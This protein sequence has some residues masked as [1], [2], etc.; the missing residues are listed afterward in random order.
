MAEFLTC[1]HSELSKRICVN[2]FTPKQV[3]AD[4]GDDGDNILYSLE[5]VDDNVFSINPNTG[6]ISLLQPLDREE[7]DEWNF[8]VKAT[9]EGGMEGF[10]EVLV[11]VNNENDN[12]PIMDPEYVGSVR[13]DAVV[14]KWVL[15]HIC[16]VYLKLHSYFCSATHCNADAVEHEQSL[17]RQSTHGQD[18]TMT[19][20]S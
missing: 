12:P 14:G 9:D 4:D 17:S 16:H 18:C 8:L 13:E 3:S 10:A 20:D 5:G 2:N 19:S 15:S 1:T 6:D 11:A 7:E